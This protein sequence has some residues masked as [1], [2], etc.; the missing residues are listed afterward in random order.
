MNP[1]LLFDFT[2]NKE[3]NTISVTRE[4]AASL[5]LVW[6]AWTKPEILDQWWAPEPWRTVT[7]TMDF[8]PGGFWLYAMVGPQDEKQWSRA[9]YKKMDVKKS[10][11]DTKTFCDDEGNVHPGTP[12]SLWNHVFSAERGITMVTIRIQYENAA[13][14]EMMMKKGFKEG[15]TKGLQNLDQ[16]ISAGK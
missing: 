8:R 2:V 12:R 7:K 3:N 16:Y 1:D 15:F 11:S 5:D 4:F 6:D 10:F 9:D 13:H 14:L